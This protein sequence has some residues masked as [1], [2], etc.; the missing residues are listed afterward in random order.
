M[1]ASSIGALPRN[2]E[3]VSNIRRTI[4]SAVIKVKMTLYTWLWNRVKFVNQVI[5]VVTAIS[6]KPNKI[7]KLLITC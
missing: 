7:I 1:N 3:Q 5:R 4:P 2:Q 6:S